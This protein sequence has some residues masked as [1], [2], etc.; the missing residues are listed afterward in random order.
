MSYKS[1][2]VPKYRSVINPR[3]PKMGKVFPEYVY[4]PSHPSSSPSAQH[5]PER[6]DLQRQSENYC[7]NPSLCQLCGIRRWPLLEAE[8]WMRLTA[9]PVN[10][11]KNSKEMSAVKPLRVVVAIFCFYINSQKR[12]VFDVY[13]YDY[14]LL[15]FFSFLAAGDIISAIH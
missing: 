9:C 14:I 3:G 1:R 4:F 6:T 8:S 5:I 15:F 2:R 11:F 13:F 12:N 7:S 10:S